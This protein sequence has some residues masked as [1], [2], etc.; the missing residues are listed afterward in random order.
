MS[1]PLQGAASSLTSRQVFLMALGCALA[2]SAIY[3][4]QPLLPEIAAAFGLSPTRGN[5]IAT[6]TQLGYALGLLLFVPL[7]DSMQPRRLATTAI[8]GNALML[9]GCALAPSFLLLEVASFFVGV[10][11]ITAQIIIPSASGMV[12]PERRGRTVGML[13][14]GLSSGVLLARTLSGF[15]G[16]HFGWRAMFALAA[17]FDLAL[18]AVVARLPV[19]TALSTI[20]YRDL[21]RS[22]L[23]LIRTE[24]ALRISIVTGFLSFGAFS[25]FWATLA[26]L[27]AQ[28]PYQFGPATVG[29]FGLVGLI[30][31]VASPHIGALVDRVHANL[32]SMAGALTALAAFAVIAFGAAHLAWLLV[33]MLLLDLGNR[34]VF[35][36]NQA[37]IYGL[38]AEA[39]SR[40][41]TVFM[42]S[43]FLGGAGGAAV[44]GLGAHAGGWTGLAAVG[45][46]LVLLAAML[47][48]C[49]YLQRDQAVQTLPPH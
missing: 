18:I 44:G 47:S 45:A 43:Y 26:A 19:A 7:A 13:L 21:M 12:S 36:A 23:S 48:A 33:G 29:A 41:N 25:A 31:L 6:I 15:V 27:L 28:P 14:G 24:P 16:A 5:Q 34:A 8:T 30:G 1:T 49:G 2:V 39:R 10:T 4:H 38:R 37:R 22:L 35:V 32:V 11:A 46:V 9:L 17:A 42:V 20:R 3:Y 40:L